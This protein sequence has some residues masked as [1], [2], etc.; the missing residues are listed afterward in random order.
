[1]G[2]KDILSL[3]LVK[4][5]LI[6]LVAVLLGVFA[7]QLITSYETRYLLN[8]EFCGSYK[9]I[10]VYK[11]GEINGENAAAHL[12][13]LEAVPYP[14]AD[15]CSSIYLTGGSFTVPVIGQ[16]NGQALGLTQNKT[17]YI[18][19]DSF[20]IDVLYHELFHCYDNANGNISESEEFLKLAE[21]EGGYF[22]LE[23]YD[24]S[25]KPAEIFASAGAMYLLEPEHLLFE[26]PQIYAYI[27]ERI[28]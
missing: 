8:R 6:I 7:G 13:L 12:R 23:G 22:Y 10:N 19:T 21:E 2:L 5:T 9:G 18:S 1:M 28:N 24:E 3:R 20:G 26:A 15:S 17:I 27:N 16:E 11:C 4:W 25:A 14:L